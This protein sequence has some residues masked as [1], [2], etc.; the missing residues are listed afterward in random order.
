MNLHQIRASAEGIAAKAQ[1]LYNASTPSIVDYLPV[2]E[3]EVDRRFKPPCENCSYLMETNGFRVPR[4]E[5]GFG[6]WRRVLEVIVVKFVTRQNL[7]SYSIIYKTGAKVLSAWA[8]I[9]L[10]VIQVLKRKVWLDPSG[11]SEGAIQS[12]W[13]HGAL[14]M[15]ERTT[16]LIH[17]MWQASTARYNR[18]S[19]TF[20]VIN[21][22]FRRR[23]E[24]KAKPINAQFKVVQIHSQQKW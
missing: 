18:S 5:V 4:F 3:G 19:H 1:D 22:L 16:K 15:E 9:F 11:H 8:E 12:S 13:M 2:V 24:H 14:D 7:F 20:M 17:I 21:I 6:Q 23:G 10:C